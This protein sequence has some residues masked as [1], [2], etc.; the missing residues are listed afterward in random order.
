MTSLYAVPLTEEQQAFR[1]EVRTFIAEKLRPEWRGVSELWSRTDMAALGGWTR[2]LIAKGWATYDWP[3]EYGGRPLT[4]MQRYI[5]TT[6]TGS[7]R[8][9]L[10]PHVNIHMVGMLICEFGSEWQKSH[11]LPRILDCSDFWSQGFSE[12]EAGSDLASLRT[13]AVC[14]GNDYVVNGQK[15]WTT[16]AH[17]ATELFTLVRT[18]PD[19]ASRQKGLSILLIPLDSPGLTVRPRSRTSGDGRTSPFCWVARRDSAPT[20]RPSS[21]TASS[22]TF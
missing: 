14:D 21:S 9:P 15:I 3:E 17:L 8:A 5:L 6:E 4:L 7:A 12:P 16:N 11:F 2:E 22:P 13:T 1:D 19:A 18:D 10:I 20:N